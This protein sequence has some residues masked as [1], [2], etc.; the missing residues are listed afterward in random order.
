MIA[1]L[2]SLP[3]RAWD[4][5]LTAVLLFFLTGDLFTGSFDGTAFVPCF[6]AVLLIALLPLIRRRAPLT[7]IYGWTLATAVLGWGYGAA[8]NF[9]APILG[10]F[11]FPYNA[12]LRT[13]GRRAYAALPAIWVTAAASALTNPTVVWGDLIFPAV[14]GTLFWL[15]GR[16]IASRSRLTA[17]LHEAAVRAGEELELDA[18]R[19]VADERRRIARE[20]H[21]VVAHSVSMMVVQ[22]GG[23]R[24]ILDRDA[25][26]RD[27]RG[28][29]DRADRPRGARRDAPPARDPARRPSGRVRAAADAREGRRADGAHARGRPPRRARGRRRAAGAP[30]RARPGRLPRR[31]GGADERDQARRRRGHRGARALRVPTRWRCS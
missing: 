9:I 4:V 31:A 3:D 22:A 1:R 12:G 13:P 21:D 10:L 18:A 26:A 8:D 24:R 27:R 17:E 14:F 16:A 5:A 29:A 7:A 2:R 25:G 30:A 28:G 6:A 11:I 19:A 20:L 15:V 23:A